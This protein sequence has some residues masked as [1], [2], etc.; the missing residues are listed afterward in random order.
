FDLDTQRMSVPERKKRK[1]TVKVDKILSTFG[2]G[3][4][5]YKDWASLVGSLQHVCLIVPEL[6][7][8]MRTLYAFLFRYRNEHATRR[9]EEREV[10][11]LREWKT[12]L[13]PGNDLSSSF[14]DA[15]PPFHLYLISDACK[16]GLGVYVRGVVEEG[17]EEKILVE[18]AALRP[19]WETAFGEDGA[20]MCNAE[21]WGTEM[22][23]E[24]AV[25]LGA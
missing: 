21:A 3:A 23:L 18:Y 25:K 20:Y 19:D 2:V 1:Y 5:K 8:R 6:R 9:V 22:L 11:A 24:S 14:A 12:L 4:V 15:P 13:Q 10:K 7:S 17:G 16:K